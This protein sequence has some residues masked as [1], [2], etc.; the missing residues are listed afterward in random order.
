MAGRGRR[1]GAEDGGEKGPGGPGAHP[2]YSGEVGWSRG[3]PAAMNFG[4]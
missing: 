4:R 3:A 1:Y 2:G